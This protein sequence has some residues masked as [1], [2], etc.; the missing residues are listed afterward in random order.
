MDYIQYAFYVGILAIV[1]LL[2]YLPKKNQEKKIKQMQANL[3]IG[4]KIVTYSGLS[5]EIVNIDNDEVTVQTSPD[6]VK[7]TIEKWAIAGNKE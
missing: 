3:K 7:L 6:N 4:D 2:V 1:F 5:G